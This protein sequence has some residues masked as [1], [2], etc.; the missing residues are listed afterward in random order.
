MNEELDVLLNSI[1]TT[2]WRS[3]KDIAFATSNNLGRDLPKAR[4]STML[5]RLEQKG[6]VVSMKNRNRLFYRKVR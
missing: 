3:A 1:S 4:V 2:A 6:A 5:K